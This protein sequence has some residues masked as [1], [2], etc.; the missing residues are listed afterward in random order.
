MHTLVIIMLFLKELKLKLKLNYL[1]NITILNFM[2]RIRL[3]LTSDSP[4]CSCDLVF[5]LDLFIIDL[6]ISASEK[7]SSVSDDVE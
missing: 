6:L 7:Y 1:G 3:P 2:I 5:D 4:D